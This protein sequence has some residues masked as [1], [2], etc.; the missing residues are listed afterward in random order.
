MT[1]DGTNLTGHLSGITEAQAAFD[2]IDGLVLGGGLTEA[3]VDARVTSGALQPANIT[4]GAN[5]TVTTSADGV[6]IASSGGGGGVAGTG[7]QRIE[8][9][10]FANI[11]N[12]L[13]T[14]TTL[15]LAATTPVAVEF[16]DGA[17][18]MLSGTG[19]E[20]T[21]TIAEAGV[22]VFEFEAI[23]PA[24]GDRTTPFVEIQDNSDDSVIG[25][26]TNAYLRNT[27][28]PEDGLT[29]VVAGVVDGPERKSRGQG[30]ARQCVQPEQP[31]RQPAGS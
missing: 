27:G 11:T 1:V 12:I 14:A 22:Y 28:S 24:D 16:G 30:G 4:A 25:Q 3:Q 10:T 9:V 26:S 19:G 8:S 29:V 7:E 6:T 21:F 31:G 13:A 15:T 2:L 20:T 17:A 18:S 5:V 23:Y